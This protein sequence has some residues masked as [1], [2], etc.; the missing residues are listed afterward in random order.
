MRNRHSTI[1]AALALAVSLTVPALGMAQSTERPWQRLFGKAPTKAAEDGKRHAEIAI[2]L[3]WLADPITFPYFLEARTEAGVLEVR[4]YIPNK[5]VREHA[6]R[7]AQVHTSL[8]V[9]DAMKEHP[10]LQ[11]RPGQLS[12]AQL[13]N[14]V[15]SSL[16]EALPRHHTQLK[17]QCGPDGKVTLRGAVNSLEEKLL[18]SQALRRLHGCT[19]VQ[20]LTQAPGESPAP[21][22][23]N[24]AKASPETKQPSL[25]PQFGSPTGKKETK[26]P[27][28]APPVTAK[29]SRQPNTEVAAARK[30]PAAPEAQGPKLPPE[31]SP[32]TRP[33]M[34]DPEIIIEA[35]PPTPPETKAEEKR[36]A[37]DKSAA[38][39]TTA[40]P[41]P[42]EKPGPAL[43]ARIQKRLQEKCKGASDIRV[44]FKASGE[45]RIEMAVRSESQ[46]TAMA[47]SI[48]ELS[49]LA[50][51]REKLDLQFKIAQ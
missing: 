50:E 46:I 28:S 5:M 32:N 13:H 14:S 11:V 38:P 8:S 19:S 16:R 21:D 34:K 12:P 41:A 37:E 3:A 9:A 10:S 4:G 7:L 49:E 48:L 40:P 29:P 39:E 30:E 15:Q 43:A 27:E 6:L 23:P 26:P 31:P 51:Y 33:A 25:R 42:K 44:E 2:E 17:V 18:A 24:V 36:A 22:T 35:V 20:N 47:V 1:G 45:L